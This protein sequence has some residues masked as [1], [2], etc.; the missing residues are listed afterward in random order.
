MSEASAKFVAICIGASREA[1]GEE[2][3]WK[4]VSCDLPSLLG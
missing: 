2:N 1:I 4:L 3:R